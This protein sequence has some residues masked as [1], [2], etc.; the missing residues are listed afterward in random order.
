MRR[1]A[2][3]PAG[4]QVAKALADCVI[5]NEY[6]IDAAGKTRIGG[7]ICCAL[8]GKLLA[9]PGQHAR[10]VARDS[11][12]HAVCITPNIGVCEQVRVLGFLCMQ[13]QQA[14]DVLFTGSCL[15]LQAAA[16]N[17]RF[18]ILSLEAK[19]CTVSGERCRASMPCAG[20]SSICRK[21]SL[22]SESGFTRAVCFRAGHGRH[23]RAGVAPST[24]TQTSTPPPTA[25]AKDIPTPLPPAGASRRTSDS[26]FLAAAAAAVAAHDGLSAASAP[27]R[28]DS[29]A[30]GMLS[31]DSLNKGASPSSTGAYLTALLNA[32]WFCT[33]CLHHG[34]SSLRRQP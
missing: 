10:G 27:A 20:R 16:S 23:E 28:M 34:A 15:I 7:K 12:A 5:P 26:S 14:L 32:E 19:L 17:A 3:S 25:S 30:A 21:G 33:F 13:C 24:P 8:L 29:L 11:G 31:D 2:E 9:D 22:C 6:G 18:M 1:V 4:A